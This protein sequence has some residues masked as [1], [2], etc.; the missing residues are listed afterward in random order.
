MMEESS[1]GGL[2]SFL[3]LFKE[4]FYG[5]AA[6][7]VVG[8]LDP[9]ML[10]RVQVQLPFI[11]SSDASPWARVAVPMVGNATGTYFIP[12]VGD[13]VLVAFEHGDVNVPYVIGSLWSSNAPPPYASP[14]LQLRTISTPAQNEITFNDL[15]PT[16]TI[17]TPMGQTVEL[18]PTGIKISCA[19]SEVTL[20]TTPPSVKITSGANVVEM[21]ADGMS[22]TGSPKLSLTASAELSLSAPM[23]RIN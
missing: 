22:L 9:L 7:S 1:G 18:S 8:V 12:S 13:A 6:G 10:G 4:K 21:K 5:V 23:V 2:V 20:T 3:D 17:S 11:D 16:I 19:G 14:V 15:T